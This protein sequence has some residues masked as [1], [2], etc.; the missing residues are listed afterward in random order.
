MQHHHIFSLIRIFPSFHHLIQLQPFFNLFS[1][2]AIHAHRKIRCDGKQPGCGTC[3]RVA[4]ECVY[5]AVDPAENARIR[6]AKKERKARREQEKSKP[7]TLKRVSSLSS[8]KRSS[9]QAAD[10]PS[11]SNFSREKDRTRTTSSKTDETATT[12]SSSPT[13]QKS[14]LVQRRRRGATFSSHSRVGSDHFRVLP[15]HVEV[16]ELPALSAISTPTSP[17]L[18]NGLSD[19]LGGESG[20]FSWPFSQSLQPR[21]LSPSTLQHFQPHREEP[22]FGLPAVQIDEASSSMP[23]FGSRAYP[24]NPAT[25]ST[26]NRSS[27]TDLFLQTTLGGLDSLFQTSEHLLEARRPSLMDYQKVNFFA[28]VRERRISR[29]EAWNSNAMSTT[30]FDGQQSYGGQIGSEASGVL[31]VPRFNDERTQ[32]DSS[33]S[34]QQSWGW[35]PSTQVDA[36]SPSTS[37]QVEGMAVSSPAT[38]DST[39]SHQSR[40]AMASGMDWADTSTLQRGMNLNQSY[41]SSGSVSLSHSQS[42]S[43]SRSRA[44]SPTSNPSPRDLA[45]EPEISNNRYEPYPP[46]SSRRAAAT[47]LRLNLNPNPL[48]SQGGDSVDP[49]VQQFFSPGQQSAPLPRE[50]AWNYRSP[51]L[52]TSDS[53]P[54]DLSS[55]YPWTNQQSPNLTTS[56]PQFSN[57]QNQD[58]RFAEHQRPFEQVTSD[59]QNQNQGEAWNDFLTNENQAMNQLDSLNLF[60]GDGENQD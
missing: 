23:N 47:D 24:P 21:A 13:G 57:F 38:P 55:E 7:A 26:H 6:Q 44:V 43:G 46:S 59:Q 54:G 10:P 19:P 42:H 33:W 14:T 3:E 20:D 50:P 40:L 17:V 34:N 25:T 48:V 4:N 22:V 58:L 39:L 60:P 37:A 52:L 5:E 27:S 29:A 30:P 49:L 28:A 36:Y 2:I 12:I 9:R 41:S 35:T 8:S 1:T 16:P 18:A 51:P 53:L 11:S 31:P 15:S 32:E 56:T 45:N